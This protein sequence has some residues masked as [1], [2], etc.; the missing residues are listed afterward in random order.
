MPASMSQG[1]FSMTPKSLALGKPKWLWWYGEGGGAP[2]GHALCSGSRGHSLCSQSPMESLMRPG[3]SPSG[4]GW[5]DYSGTGLTR[6]EVEP[7]PS[8]ARSSSP[9]S[10]VPAPNTLLHAP[11]SEESPRASANRLEMEGSSWPAGKTPRLHQGGPGVL[12][13]RQLKSLA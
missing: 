11:H 2:W 10:E 5:Q 9:F 4:L 8:P 1:F 6:Q 13:P 7:G 3:L 12:L